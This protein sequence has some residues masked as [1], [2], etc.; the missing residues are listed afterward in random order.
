MSSAEGGTESADKGRL[1]QGHRLSRDCRFG[2]EFGDRRRHLRAA[3]PESWSSIGLASPWLFLIVGVLVVTIV[4][5]FAE[6]ASYF[7]DSGGPVSV[8]HQSFRPAGRLRH[9]LDLLH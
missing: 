3:R 6:L 9:G 7:R 8:H 5:T 2:S 1:V 4:L